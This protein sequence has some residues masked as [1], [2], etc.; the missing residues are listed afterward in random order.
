[1][2]IK[3]TKL[4]YTLNVISRWVVGLVFLFSS[5]VK[6]VDPMGTMFKVQDYMSSWEIFGMTFE[7]AH[8]LAG[9]L[10]MA[11][12][13]AEFVIGV[14][15]IFNSF[16]VLTAWLLALMMLFFTATTLVDATTDLVKDCG[17]FGDAIKL[18]NWQTFWKNIVLDVPTVWIVLTCRLRMKRRFERDVIVLVA[19]LAAMLVFGI[20]NVR[21][22]PV[23]DFRPWKVGNEM[24]KKQEPRNFLKYTNKESGEE[25]VLEYTTGE[26]NEE[27]NLYNEEPWEFADMGTTLAF[28]L[29]DTSFT[30]M[31][32]EG[33]DHSLDL[34]LSEEGVEIVT[35][36]DLDKVDAEGVEEIRR[37]M[38]LA[39][40]DGSDIVILTATSPEVSLETQADIVH[41]WL[42]DHSLSWVDCYYADDTSIK[43]V[44]RGNPGFVYVKDGVVVAKSRK[45]LE[46][47]KE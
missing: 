25:K 42:K 46:G 18:T 11:L 12:I 16:R 23:I 20:Y 33:H 6:G 2:K 28:V 29:R 35:I 5:F 14:M 41:A 4:N 13:C 45:A 38:D 34:I 40:E 32:V 31:D 22:E 17:C 3:D 9:V 8:P 1:M 26:W 15:L 21:H 47:L 19:A 30:M 37:A 43:V 36:W 10:A 39:E 44:L 24:V 7:W 27:W